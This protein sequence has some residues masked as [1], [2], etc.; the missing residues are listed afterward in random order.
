MMSSRR[1]F[2]ANSVE[3]AVAQARQEL[4]DETLLVE[5]GATSGGDRHLGPYAATVETEAPSVGSIPDPP[6][7]LEAMRREG[8]H[9]G[10]EA[11][12]SEIGR[13]SVLVRSLASHLPSFSYMPELTAAAAHLEA[14]GL[15]QLLVSQ[16]L[17]R[18]ERRLGLRQ[19]QDRLSE[20]PVRRGIAAE[21]ES[22]LSVGS[23]P[24]QPEGHRR[25]L[26]L[27][28]PP[29]AG[30]TTTLT[31]LAMRYGVSSRAPSVILSTDCYRV[32]AAEQ[33]RAY[34]AILGLPFALA[35]NSGALSRLLVE[36]RHKEVV[37]IDTPGCGPSD[38]ECFEEWARAFTSH[39]EI[40]RHLV[41]PA[42]ARYEDLMRGWRR[43]GRLKPARLI[44]THID[45][46]AFHGSWLG[47][48]ISTGL[49]ISCLGTGQ[50][51][52]EDLEMASK[53]LLM[54][55]LFGGA[56]RAANA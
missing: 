3:S 30:K 10:L 11:I 15:P 34:A 35:E 51:V 29:G 27:V 9:T 2:Y 8:D 13:L 23:G 45:E 44:F 16:I 18:V 22:L 39:P 6:A 7:I 47:F 12:Q 43:W 56:A 55:L 46:T 50:R 32:A 54:D 14:S 40:E 17:E 42:T 52:P 24:E 20:L 33:L 41:L 36:Q 37:L 53:P 1:T 48:A 19:S 5:A 4:G 26:A 49:P 25:V 31:K 21:L 28:G 38:L